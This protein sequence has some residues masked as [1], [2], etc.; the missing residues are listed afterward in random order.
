MENREEFHHDDLLERAVDAVLRDPMPGELP[1][2]Q[3]A[4]L[5][6]AVR[7][8]ADK[9]YPITFI[10]RIENMKLRTRIAV[11][12]AVLVAC[13]GLMSWLVPGSGTALAFGDVVEALNSV[14]SATWKTA[15]EVKRPKN[16]AVAWSGTGMFLAPSHERIETTSGGKK[17]IQIYDGKKDKAIILDQDAKTVTVINLKNLP[18]ESP[19]GRTFQG[20]RDLVASAQNG[21]A[22][23]AERLDVNN[24]DGRPAQGF[25]IHLGA[26]EVKIWADPKTL[27]PIRVEETGGDATGSEVR[28]VMSDFQVGAHLDESLFSLD[29][30]AGY[31]IQET[32]QIDLSKKPA[33]YL[34][35]ALKWAAEHNDGVFP[36]A[37]RGE[38]GLDGVMRRAGAEMAKKFAN[39]KPEMTKLVT[40]MSMKLGGAFGFLFALPPDAWHYAGKDVKLNAPNRPIFWYQL[41]TDA[42]CTVIYADLSIKEVPA[43]EAPKAPAKGNP[44][45]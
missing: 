28:I 36:A 19:Y 21:G 43:E 24:I 12:A 7:Q 32:M 13:V 44:K 30:P 6:A 33:A 4:Q 20:F 35:D 16:E 38:E 23:K 22:F 5:V 15:T 31:T 41:K 2:D 29:A 10:E 17:S 3:V 37:I 8:A 1:P 27:L 14:Q 42:K 39:N 34:A 26:V 45:K 11:A 25:R 18:S 40:D 9:P